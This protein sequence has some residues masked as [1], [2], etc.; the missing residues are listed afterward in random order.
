MGQV[1]L[2]QTRDGRQAAVKLLRA[3]FA[4]S[5]EYR[6]RF[7]REFAAAR[8]VTGPHTAPVFDADPQA[9]RPWFASAYVPGPTLHEHVAAHGP[10][11]AA[12]AAAL[13]A[14]LVGGLRAIHAMGLVHRDLKP[15][16]VII[17]GHGP[18]II[19]FGISRS[20]DASTLTAT[21]TILGTYG[22]MAPE[23]ITA[24]TAS[25]ASD[26]FALGC[27]LAFAANGKGPFDASTIA[28]VI[29]RVVAEPPE[30]GG[31]TGDLRALVESCLAKDPAQRPAL[32]ELASRL[33]AA[34]GPT[35]APTLVD[36]APGPGFAPGQADARTWTG[37]R[38]TEPFAGPTA[39]R[40]HRR[41]LNRRNLLI[42]AGTAAV[43]TAVPVGW[44]LW[45]NRHRLTDEDLDGIA[46]SPDGT[47][48]AAAMWSGGTIRIWDAHT[49][50]VLVEGSGSGVGA[51]AFSPD[52]SV[53]V[54]AGHDT[55]VEFRDPATGLATRS[56]DSPVA[57]TNVFAFNAR[58]DRLLQGGHVPV[59]TPDADEICAVWD[60]ESGEVTAVLPFASA[61]S[62]SVHSALFLDE[63][64]VLIAGDQLT[65]TEYT[66]G[67]WRWRLDG[68]GIEPIGPESV[69]YAVAMSS[70]GRLA[71]GSE[72][73]C[74]LSLDGSGDE[75][76]QIS[77]AAVDAVA[78][79]PDGAAL[80]VADADGIAL[81]D[82]GTAQVA[83][84][85]TDQRSLQ[86][87]FD[88]AGTR[89]ASG[90]W[91]VGGTGGWLWPID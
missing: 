75:F 48:V 74:W 82:V 14:G 61:A 16:N 87:T 32:P 90:G 55:P 53:L 43:G 13:G 18:V 41:W 6:E 91:Y 49:R 9:A 33:A 4:S 60:V 20:I 1:Y 26:A 44:N 40:P 73:G 17:A 12:T 71:L 86:L 79:T 63:D 29:H 51:L 23:Q 80:A 85:V 24:D 30:L 52:S 68:S 46:I 10:L 62:S 70:Q 3:E 45:R 27:V 78:F 54:T 28:A 58:G 42:A 36:P 15:G 21:G 81:W 5:P 56:L 7:A 25:P 37:D 34:A 66:A 88:D 31:L 59:G 2:G 47:I 50:D 65:G 11:P 39:P 35:P 67:F 22:Y 84:T 76:S 72:E 19:D 38:P 57:T 83:R 89:L 64:T 8:S 69:G 77:S